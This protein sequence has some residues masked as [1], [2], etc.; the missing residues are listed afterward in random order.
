VLIFIPAMSHA[1]AK[2]FN[3]DQ[4]QW[5]R[6]KVNNIRLTLQYPIMVYSMVWLHLSIQF[7][8]IMKRK[9]DKMH[10]YQVQRPQ[11]MALISYH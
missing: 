4:I 10:P 1:T 3:G 7:L 6:A 2:S 11:R 8:H 9:G 5:K